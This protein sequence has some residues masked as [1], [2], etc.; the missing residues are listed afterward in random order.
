M[1]EQSLQ[2]YLQPI[3]YWDVENDNVNV[4][5]LH[6]IYLGDAHWYISYPNTVNKSLKEG[7]PYLTPHQYSQE[8]KHVHYLKTLWETEL[9][10]LRKMLHVFSHLPADSTREFSTGPNGYRQIE[11]EYNPS[12]P[13]SPIGVAITLTFTCKYDNGTLQAFAKATLDTCS[14]CHTEICQY[15]L[16]IDMGGIADISPFLNGLQHTF[17]HVI[18]ATLDFLAST[19]E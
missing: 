19:H 5:V 17:L 14:D 15:P 13:L 4:E 7:R 11:W 10:L 8:Q 9:V 12:I 18:A 1:T 6:K 3:V 16:P 2:L